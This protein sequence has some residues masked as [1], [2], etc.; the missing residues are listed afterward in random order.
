MEKLVIVNELREMVKKYPDYTMGEIIYSFTRPH[1]NK[2][3][4]GK[5]SEL[6]KITDKQM[7]TNLEKAIKIEEND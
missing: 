5:L 7:V 4:T 3:R 1:G 6:L 2:Y